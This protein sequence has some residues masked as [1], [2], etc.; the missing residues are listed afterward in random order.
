MWRKCQNVFSFL[1]LIVGT[2]YHCNLLILRLHHCN[3]LVLITMIKWMRYI[4]HRKCYFSLAQPH[5]Y[6][7][8]MLSRSFCFS[9]RICRTDCPNSFFGRDQMR[10]VLR[11]WVSFLDV[12]IGCYSN[13]GFNTF[14]IVSSEVTFF[15]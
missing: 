4:F 15:L 8:L 1:L 13:A 9:D 7:M 14:D 5:H 12:C 6:I 10:Y 2:L 3:A 11:R